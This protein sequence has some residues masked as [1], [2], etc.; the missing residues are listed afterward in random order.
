[1]EASAIA[2]GLIAFID[3]SP[4]PYHACAT[5]AAALDDAGFDRVVETDTWSGAR[6]SY[7]VRGGSLVAWSVP[8]GWSPTVGFRL[9]GAHT[10]SPNLRIKPRPDTGSAG[11]RQLGVEVYGGALLNTWLDRDLGLSGRVA[12]R[13]GAGP[14]IRLFRTDRPL[15][16]VPQLAIHLDREINER[17][18]KLHRQPGVV[19]R[20]HRRAHGE[21]RRRAERGCGRVPLRPRGGRQPVEHRRR[22]HAAAHRART[23]RARRRRRP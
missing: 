1:M 9:I 3:G 13:N 4:S 10:D 17:G 5:A 18:L 12:V 8:D 23:H 2:D 6:R 7:V 11:Y 20:R 16:R 19:P 14:E 22:R 15:L 21:P